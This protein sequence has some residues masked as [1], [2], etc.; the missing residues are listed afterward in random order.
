M[1]PLV[2]ATCCKTGAT[3]PRELEKREKVGWRIVI[4][5]EERE[6]EAVT[7][8]SKLMKGG[9]KS[10]IGIGCIIKKKKPQLYW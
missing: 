1:R 5:R 8:Y 7:C 4:R 6:S 9:Q 3:T 10:W 2:A